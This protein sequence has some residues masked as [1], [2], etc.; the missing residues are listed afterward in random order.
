MNKDRRHGN[1]DETRPQSQSAMESTRKGLCGQKYVFRLGIPKCVFSA[2]FQEILSTAFCGGQRQRT[3]VYYYNSV[4]RRRS[5]S[6][7]S[8]SVR[9]GAR[10]AFTRSDNNDA[11]GVV[12]SHLAAVSI[13]RNATP[14]A[15][16]LCS[17]RRGTTQSSSWLPEVFLLDDVTYF[18]R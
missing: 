11:R 15:R 16:P 17:L 14:S 13:G 1:N 6:S 8:Q 7:V 2:S 4:S 3:E 18:L 9:R 5:A 12:A 10:S